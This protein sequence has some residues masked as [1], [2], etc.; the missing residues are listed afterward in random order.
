MDGSVNEL[1]A[2]LLAEYADALAEAAPELPEGTQE[3]LSGFVQQMITLKRQIDAVESDL[4]QMKQ[5]YDDVRKRQLPDLMQTL[6]L[7]GPDGKGRFTHDSGARVHLT[8]KVRASYVKSAEDVFFRWLRDNGHNSLIKETVH[9][10]TLA[11]LA[12]E[13]MENG[14]PL[15]PELSAFVETTAVITLPKQGEL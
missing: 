14:E 11:S 2:D 6:G 5:E 1:P 13:L 4:V 10:Q 8:H 3:T 15:P 12:K 9:P 7:I